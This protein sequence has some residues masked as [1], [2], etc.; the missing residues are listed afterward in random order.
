MKAWMGVAAIAVWAAV[1][2]V[3]GTAMARDA[4]QLVPIRPDPVAPN[5][6]QAA[7]TAIPWRSAAATATTA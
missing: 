4:R 7:S 2:T 1:L 3:S 6:W 5:V